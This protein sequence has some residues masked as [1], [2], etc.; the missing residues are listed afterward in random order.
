[1]MNQGEDINQ[2]K[3]FLALNS[4]IRVGAKTFARLLSHFKSDLAKVWLAKK[5]DLQKAGLPE[6]QTEAVLRIIQNVNPDDEL[7]KV[8]QQNIEVLTILDKK[9]PT[10]LKEIFDPPAVLYFK[11]IMPTPQDFLLGVVGSRACTSYGRQA[12]EELSFNLARNGLTIVSGLALGIDSIAH[13]AVLDA[14]GKTIAVLGCGLDTIYPYSH[15]KLA[16]EIINSDGAIISEQHIGTKPLR[17][18]F[19]LRNRIISGLSKATLI[20]EAA[21]KSGA[22]ITARSALEQNREVFVVPGSIYSPKSEGT[23][24]LIK[25]GAHPVTVYQDI[26]VELNIKEENRNKKEKENKGDNQ[27]EEVLLSL[28]DDGPLAV[29]KLVESSGLEAA[30]VNSTLIMLEMKG[31]VKSIGGGSY[32]KT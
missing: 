8:A 9:Y 18:F 10:D 23:N 7:E 32:I 26:L 6:A 27:E 22:L 19:P 15:R 29:D 11:G 21:L 4:D 14:K 2:T 1:M 20:V 17:P 25:M 30:V 5:I 28:L 24:N 16:D 13:R 31:R 3:Y 12:A